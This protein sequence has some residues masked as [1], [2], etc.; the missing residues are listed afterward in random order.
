MLTDC[1]PGKGNYLI[2]RIHTCDKKLTHYMCNIVKD[3]YAALIKSE[4]E[5][6]SLYNFHDMKFIA[7]KFSIF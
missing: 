4:L 7:T 2:S 3:N 6:T 5:Y 1:M